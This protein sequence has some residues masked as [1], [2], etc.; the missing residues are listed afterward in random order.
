MVSTDQAISPLQWLK[1]QIGKPVKALLQPI[2]ASQPALLEVLYTKGL[3]KR[4]A[5]PQEQGMAY[6]QLTS[7]WEL[8][9]DTCPCDIQFCEYVQQAQIAGK[10]VF[11]FG[12]GS[13]HLIGVDNQNRDRPN[14]IMGI[15]ASL[16]EHQTYVQ[17]IIKNPALA[18]YYKVL[19]VDIYTLTAG[20]LPRLDI[21]NLFH[22]CEF[23]LPENAS[24]LHHTDA[25]LLQLFVDQLQPD[26]QIIFYSGSRAWVDKAQAIVQEFE[27]S[28][29]IKRVGEY[30]SLFIYQRG[31]I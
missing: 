24:V 30:K 6:Y 29:K 12:T 25:S 17:L 21:V 19:F 20:N 14:E 16:P 9:P 27:T 10:S 2:L 26:G 31:D 13:H 28:G 4:P 7:S 11:H 8:L 22:L 18:K 15:T 23:Y 3:L 5:L 1:Q